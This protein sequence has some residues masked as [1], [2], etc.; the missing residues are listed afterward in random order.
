[1]LAKILNVGRRRRTS[2]DLTPKRKAVGAGFSFGILFAW[3]LT[4]SALGVGLKQS[5]PTIGGLI[6]VVL[7]LVGAWHS[8]YREDD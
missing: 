6:L 5:V 4:S 7:A 1:M 2:N 3:G 8:A